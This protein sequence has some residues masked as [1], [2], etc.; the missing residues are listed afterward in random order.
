MMLGADLR[1][2]WCDEGDDLMNRRGAFGAD[3]RK[4]CHFLWGRGLHFG[5][6]SV[7][8]FRVVSLRFR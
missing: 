3:F 8:I 4:I 5:V 6:W 1:K 2:I 7:Y